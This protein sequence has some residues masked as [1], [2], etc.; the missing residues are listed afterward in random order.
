MQGARHGTGSRDSRIMP[1]DKG[2]LSTAE[3]PWRPDAAHLDKEL[4]V[5]EGTCGHQA[6]LCP[7]ICRGI[8]GPGLAWLPVSG[9]PRHRPAFSPCDCCP[10]HLLNPGSSFSRKKKAVRSNT[11]FKSKTWAALGGSAV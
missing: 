8:T 7:G 6:A 11:V 2:R 4:R 10:G 9:S 5:W 3:P 1:W